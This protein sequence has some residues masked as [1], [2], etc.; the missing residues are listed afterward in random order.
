MTRRTALWLASRM[1]RLGGAG[2]ARSLGDGDAR[3]NRDGASR[4]D[5]QRRA[6][7]EPDNDDQ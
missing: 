6:G 3:G 5:A 2:A 1:A 4:G 7:Q